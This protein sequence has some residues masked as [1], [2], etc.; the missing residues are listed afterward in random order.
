MSGGPELVRR[1]EG[2]PLL[3]V[4]G[5]AMSSR[6]WQPVLPQL[7]RTHDVVAPTLPGHRG[8]PQAPRN[9]RVEWLADHLERLLDDLGLDDAHVVGNSLGGWLALEL[10]RRGRARSVVAISPAG[11]TRR[12][13]DQWRVEALLGSTDGFSRLP[14]S[15][16]T[17]EPSLHSGLG[18]RA[19]LRQVMEHGE[20]TTSA[21]ARELLRD[22]AG[23]RVVRP[24][25]RAG[26][27]DRFAG[28]PE[29]G[30]PV[31]VVW[32]RKDRV[33]PYAGHGRPLL[34]LLPHAAEVALPG[35][36]HVPMHDAPDVL[37]R[38]VREQVR[39]AEVRGPGRA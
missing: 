34:R 18:R 5:L 15:G 12:T 39:A 31:T 26:R 14:W 10:A 8:G 22:A 35:A 32:G 17:L 2:P 38:V 9:V 3:L 4:H 13:L 37:V 29:P 20:R 30:V 6:A 25:L 16:V 33:I 36:G 7:A 24:L 21:E 1:G 27:A 19:V 11:A 28:L 23:C